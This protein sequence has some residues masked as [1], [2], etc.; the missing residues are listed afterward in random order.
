MPAGVFFLCP[1]AER[2]PLYVTPVFRSQV[3]LGAGKTLPL[4]SGA[5]AGPGHA[6]RI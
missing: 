6:P 2:D 4:A 3:W 5:V 1:T